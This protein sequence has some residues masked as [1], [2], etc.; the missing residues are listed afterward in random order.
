MIGA[1]LKLPQ[2]FRKFCSF[3]TLVFPEC[4]Q[5]LHLALLLTPNPYHQVWIIVFPHVSHFYNHTFKIFPQLPRDGNL[6]FRRSRCVTLFLPCEFVLCVLSLD[7]CGWALIGFEIW[8]WVPVNS[9]RSQKKNGVTWGL[10]IFDPGPIDGC[11]RHCW[12][13]PEQDCIVSLSIVD[14]LHSQSSQDL[15]FNQGM[16]PST[17]GPGGW[18]GR[19]G[20]DDTLQRV[21]IWGGNIRG[22]DHISNKKVSLILI[23]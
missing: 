11:C 13:C 2:M 23:E 5:H 7:L 1:V 17:Q 15:P 20:R 8:D 4:L 19:A 14:L 18:E 6:V 21:R 16:C 10:L 12:W 22:S 9:I 3:L